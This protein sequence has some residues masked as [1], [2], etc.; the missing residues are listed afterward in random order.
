[1]AF[2]IFGFKIERK[3]QEK[4]GANVPVFTLPEN[5]DGSQMVSGAGAYGSY[6]D[7][8]GQ[9]KNEVDLILKY[10]EMSQTSDCEI[11]IDNI[12]NEAIVVDDTN[13]PVQ[14]VL[15]KTDLTEGIKNK[16]RGEF[17]TILDNTNIENRHLTL[18]HSCG[19]DM[20]EYA[21]KYE[22]DLEDWVKSN[23][24]RNSLSNKD[25]D[26]YRNTLT[27]IDYMRGI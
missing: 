1:M 21:D 2:E 5:D 16:I 9:Y 27:Y 11:A 18:H 7:I 3:S 12:I 22:S 24:C 10:R 14:I 4:P 20:V 19:V 8:E 17:E 6:L 23:G 15:D 26:C 25:Y 13:P